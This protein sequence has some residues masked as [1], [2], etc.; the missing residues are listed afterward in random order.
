MEEGKH[1]P[2]RILAFLD[3]DLFILGDFFDL[4]LSFIA[5]LV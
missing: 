5:H 4:G 3:V 2:I 1:N